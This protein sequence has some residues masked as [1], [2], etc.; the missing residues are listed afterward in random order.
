MSD[1]LLSK[2]RREEIVENI[3]DMAGDIDDDDFMEYYERDD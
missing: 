1:F 3:R 2:Q